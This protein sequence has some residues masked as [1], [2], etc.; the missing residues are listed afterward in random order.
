MKATITGTDRLN[1]YDK[2]QHLIVEVSSPKAKGTVRVHTMSTTDRLRVEGTLVLN[3]GE[4]EMHAGHACKN[5]NGEWVGEANRHSFSFMS[6][7]ATA[8]Q[9][10]LANLVIAEVCRI[11][12]QDAPFHWEMMNT[13]KYYVEMD[14]ERA[15]EKVEELKLEVLA[16]QTLINELEQKVRGY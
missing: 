7:P 13:E 15:Q 9:I 8:K 12:E 2:R 10:E 5:A 16:Q 11:A 6:A 3:G 1:G 14:L 4:R